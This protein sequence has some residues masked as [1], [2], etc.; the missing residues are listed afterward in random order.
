MLWWLRTNRTKSVD[1]VHNIWNRV[2]FRRIC[3]EWSEQNGISISE[4]ICHTMLV[5]S[6]YVFQMLFF[7]NT[8]MNP[9]ISKK[10]HFYD[11]NT[12]ELYCTHELY[13]CWSVWLS[14]FYH[15][16]TFIRYIEVYFMIALLDC[17]RY[18]EDFVKSRFCSIHFTV[19][20][21]VKKILHYT[22]NV[23]M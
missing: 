22:E 6:R 10:T 21:A 5:F 16:F 3:M 8:P 13:P 4:T 9:I 17:V 15:M 23:V 19:I 20:S 12:L 1:S 7:Q 2:K 18:N 11:V 14:F